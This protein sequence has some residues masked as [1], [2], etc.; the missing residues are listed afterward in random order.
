V[1]A[2][3]RLPS[4][5]CGLR[6]SGIYLEHD[7][8]RLGHIH[9]RNLGRATGSSVV[10]DVGTGRSY[11]LNRARRALGRHE[12][13]PAG[14]SH[15]DRGDLTR[16]Q[17]GAPGRLQFWGP[18]ANGSSFMMLRDLR[19]GD[20]HLEYDGT[21]IGYLHVWRLA[22][23]TGL[24]RCGCWDGTDLLLQASPPC[25]S[26]SMSPNPVSPQGLHQRQSHSE[27]DGLHQCRI[28][29]W[30]VRRAQ[31]RS[32]SFGTMA[33]PGRL[34]T[35]GSLL[36]HTRSASGASGRSSKLSTSE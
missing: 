21:R 1:R 20:L 18:R 14:R 32:R 9:A 28:Q 17:P 36:G 29:V 5:C 25:A 4:R 6:R 22:S 7:G 34:D 3:E 33:R 27:L 8:T 30:S 23:A 24:R 35:T 10:V 15:G 26:V 2:R 16:A 11:L 19:R 13:S 12:P 31:S